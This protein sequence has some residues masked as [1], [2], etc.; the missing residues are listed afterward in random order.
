MNVLLAHFGEVCGFRH[1]WAEEREFG[2]H[3]G[4]GNNCKKTDVRF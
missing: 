4:F 2:L 3:I 1:V